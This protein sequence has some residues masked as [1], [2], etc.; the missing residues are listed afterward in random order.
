MNQRSHAAVG[1]LIARAFLSPEKVGQ[2]AFNAVPPKVIE[3]LPERLRLTWDYVSAD[4]RLHGSADKERVKAAANGDGGA[5]VKFIA[6]LMGGDVPVDVHEI[7]LN[8]QREEPLQ[9]PA[10]P[11]DFRATDL[12][13]ARLFSHLHGGKVRYCDRLGGWHYF[14]GKR[15]ARETC[16]EVERLTKDLPRAMYQMAVNELNEAKRQAI[17]KHA[18]RT[19]AVGKLAAILELA[20]S[21]PRIAVPPEAFDAHQ[22]KFNT[23]TGTLDLQTGEERP[24]RPEDML[25]NISP[26]EWRGQDAKGDRFEKFLYE[27]MDGDQEKIDFLQRAAGYTLSGDMREQVFLFLHGPEAAGKGTF[28]RSLAD[29]MGTYARST[30]IS[31]FLTA[32]RDAVRNDVATLVGSRL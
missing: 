9:T 5:S 20:K 22:W 19:E 3:T 7:L 15:W 6:E 27:A 17:A 31:T 16:G 12:W 14:D 29:V 21:E 23:A 32:R 13:N 8:I 18:A 26:V 11:E 30:E 2:E 10:V 1:H 28:I 25:T 24:H 4:V